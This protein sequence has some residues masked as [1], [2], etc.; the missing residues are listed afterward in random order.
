MKTLKKVL[1]P[2]DGSNYSLKILPQ[3]E[4]FISPQDTELTLLR[5][6]DISQVPPQMPRNPYAPVGLFTEKMAGP[7]DYRVYMDERWKQFQQDTRDE[8][9]ASLRSLEKLGYQVK[10]M[11]QFGDPAQEILHVIDDNKFELV[12]M[13][14]HAREGLSRILFGSVTEQVMHHVN[15]PVLLIHPAPRPKLEKNAGEALATE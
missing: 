15:I 14:T 4:R 6:F 10:T 5:I 13:T 3:I 11:V 2:L 12:A 9:Q 7:D 1:V 8:L